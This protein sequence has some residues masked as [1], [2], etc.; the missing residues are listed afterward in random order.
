MRVTLLPSFAD[1]NVFLS[2]VQAPDLVG[3]NEFEPF[4]RE[5][6]FFTEHHILNREIQIIFE[7]LFVITCKLIV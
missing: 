3:D 2:G 4:G 7:G 5:A 1:I 6:K